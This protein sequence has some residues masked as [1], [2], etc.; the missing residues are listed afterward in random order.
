MVTQFSN[1]NSDAKPLI[2]APCIH[3]NPSF[4]VIEGHGEDILKNSDWNLVLVCFEAFYHVGTK[5]LPLTTLG[6]HEDVLGK[7]TESN[8][9]IIPKTLLTVDFIHHLGLAL[10]PS[11]DSFGFFETSLALLSD[12]IG[13]TFG[14]RKFDMNAFNSFASWIFCFFEFTDEHI[15]ISSL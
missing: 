7:F 2:N 13:N 14:K 5:F 4:C 11:T 10:N 9:K 12:V 8:T 1:R 6:I 15:G 3:G